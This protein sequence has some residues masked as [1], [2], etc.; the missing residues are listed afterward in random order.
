MATRYAKNV[1]CPVLMQWG[2]NDPVIRKNE[3]AKIFTALASVHKKIVMYEEAGH[4]SLLQKDPAKWR[5][6]IKQF[7]GANNQ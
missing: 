1:H 2:T 7:L 3:T 4:E 6:A 5:A